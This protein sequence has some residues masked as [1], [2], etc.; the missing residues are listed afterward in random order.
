MDEPFI[1]FWSSRRGW[2]RAEGRAD[3]GADRGYTLSGQFDLYCGKTHKITDYKTCSTW[4]IIFG[5]YND[6]RQQLLIYSWMM[7]QI[8]FPVEC[9][10]VVAMMKD[11][12]K[13]KAKRDVEYPLMPVQVITFDFFD[14]DFEEIEGWLKERFALIEKMEE[15]PDDELPLCTE[16]E[17]FNSGTK[18]AVMQKR[19]KRVEGAGQRG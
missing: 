6:W 15:L 17:R 2:T 8:G 7:R 5:D 19:R 4:K 18:Y 10:E 14:S 13:M 1:P 16:G 9:A 12:S 3:Q 11:H